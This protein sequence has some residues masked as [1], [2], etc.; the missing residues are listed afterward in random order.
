[1]NERESHRAML[2]A[3]LGD[4]PPYP[5]ERF[6][7]RGI[8]LCAGGDVYFPCAW[9]CIGM[10]RRL[11]CTLPVELWYRGPR[12]MTP[13]MI[14]LLEPL[15]VTCVDAYDVARRQPYRRLD[16]WEIK[17]FAI[18]WSR[19][20]EVL[21]LDADNVPLRDPAPL[22]DLPAY[23]ERGALFWPDRYAGPGTGIE[24][25]KREAWDAC[26]L[27]YR[28][29][30]EIEAGQLVIDKQKSWR[31]LSMTQHLNEH[32]DYY[33]AFFLGDKDTF[34][35]SW[36]RTATPYALMPWRPRTLGQSEV[37]V[38]HDAAGAPLFQHRNGGKWSL[39][40]PNRRVPGFELED[41]CLQLLDELR[42]RWTPPARVFPADFTPTESRCY[43]EL[44]AARHFEYAI[45]GGGA[46]TIE[47]C[48]DFRIGDGAATMEAAW[49]IEDDKDGQPLLSIRNANAPTCFLRRDGG[50]WRGRWLVYH[51]NRVSLRP[52]GRA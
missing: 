27:P 51:R 31:G 21:Y 22:F 10:L 1:M 46:K 20:A 33:Y 23:R 29:A 32:S 35:L 9:V 3:A 48:P 14:A 52:A 2:E 41:V 6:A 7:G 37:I 24:W 26:G 28:V 13:A 44:C 17:P 25:L 36:L 8:V 50:V 39:V 40:H 49:M 18:A 5:A 4:A 43:E 34:H 42:D 12:E 30:P 47:L 11:G 38:Q 45:D 19:F 16:S 15:G